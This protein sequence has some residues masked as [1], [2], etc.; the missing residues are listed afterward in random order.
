[1]RVGLLSGRIETGLVYVSEVRRGRRGSRRQ[2][3]KDMNRSNVYSGRGKY[4]ASS[5]TPIQSNEATRANV[6]VL[7][8]IQGQRSLAPSLSLQETD[9]SHLLP[10][11]AVASLSS[12]NASA[13]VPSRAWNVYT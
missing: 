4:E 11:L 13:D 8:L 5:H 9:A 10:C 1:M 6:G 7:P 12:Q 2:C 3:R